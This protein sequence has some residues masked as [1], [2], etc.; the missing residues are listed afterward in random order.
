M[1]LLAT[2]YARFSSTEQ[3]A[4]MS[5][6]RQFGVTKAMCEKH[7]WEFSERRCIADE[8]MSAFSGK[9]RQEGSGLFEFERKAKAGHYAN[10]HVLVVEHLDRI[11]RQGYQEVLD[12]INGLTSTGVTVATCD[13]NEVYQPYKR[14]TM[15]DV[16]KV[17]LK[18]EVALEESEKKSVRQLALWEKKLGQVRSGEVKAITKTVPSWIVVDDLSR[19]MSLHPERAEVVREI[20]Q[21]CVDGFGAPAIVKKL[22]ERHEPTWGQYTKADV[23][24]GRVIGQKRALGGWQVGQILRI[25]TNP[26][27]IGEYQPMKRARSEKLATIK[28]ERIIGFYPSAIDHDLWAR[29]QLAIAGRRQTGGKLWSRQV[30]LFS[31]IAFCGTCGGKMDYIGTATKGSERKGT[32]GSRKPMTYVVGEDISFLQCGNARRNHNCEAKGRFR[33]QRLEQYV[34]DRVLHMTLDSSHF[35]IAD[36]VASLNVEI[37]QIE[38][39]IEEQDERLTRLID[40]YARTGSAAVER[41][42]LAL[43]AEMNAGKDKLPLLREQ[44]V[45]AQGEVSPEEHQQ[46]IGE[47]RQLIGDD[48]PEVRLEARRKLHTALSKI[49]KLHCLQVGQKSGMVKDEDTSERRLLIDVLDKKV[50]TLLD[51]NGTYMASMDFRPL[52]RSNDPALDAARAFV[53]SHEAN[54]TLAEAALAGVLARTDDQTTHRYGTA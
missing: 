46:R 36:R 47:V 18:A 35:E 28:G 51:M 50:V 48:N 5:L 54:P 34:L 49:V 7:E 45:R 26:A 37:A 14:L 41:S 31:G 12:F 4:G 33:Y 42:M 22:N 16:M 27:V 44:L 2:C 39:A 38:R 40:S 23:K 15:V 10:G 8:G 3:S 52:F 21:W 43:E 13:G 53:R 29:A 9:N 32:N 30:N 20:F 19:V 1:A 11:S 24:K 6:E 17:L 25:F